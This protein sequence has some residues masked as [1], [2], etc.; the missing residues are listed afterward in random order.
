MNR[1]RFLYIARCRWVVS[2][3]PGI[4]WW[5]KSWDKFLS[6]WRVGKS[7]AL[8][9]LHNNM[10]SESILSKWRRHQELYKSLLDG[11]HEISEDFF[12]EYWSRLRERT[13]AKLSSRLP[14]EGDL[15]RDYCLL[16]KK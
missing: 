12:R 1:S 6:F 5:F 16:R 3:G 13:P 4:A 10:K 2:L 7:S 15:R 11:S 14:H 8:R 9:A